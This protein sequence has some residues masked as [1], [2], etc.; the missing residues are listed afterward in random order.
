MTDFDL[1]NDINFTLACMKT[2]NKNR[3]P[4]KKTALSTIKDREVFIQELRKEGLEIVK[5]K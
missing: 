3:N 2:E 1:A 4:L 5:I